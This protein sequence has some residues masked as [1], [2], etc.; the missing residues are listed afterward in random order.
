MHIEWRV[1]PPPY[2]NYQV[3][4]TGLVKASDGTILKQQPYNHYLS[5][6]LYSEAAG[7][8][9]WF[10]VHRLV[11]ERFVPNLENKPVVNHKDF[12]TY[13]NHSYN[14]EWVTHQENA[15]HSKERMNYNRY[16]VNQ[17]DPEGNIIQTFNSCNEAVSAMGGKNNGSAVAKAIKQGT[18]SYGYY[19]E[20][21]TTS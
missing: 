14:L 3:S 20:R 18:K 2:T 4:N 1:I 11:A 7:E 5:V 10:K 15:D 13:N 9:K 8:D 19:W 16:K 17:L 12:N 21:A 6:R